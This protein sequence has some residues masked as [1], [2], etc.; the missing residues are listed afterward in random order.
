M[1]AAQTLGIT[2]IIDDMMAANAEVHR[3][4]VLREKTIVKKA[5]HWDIGQTWND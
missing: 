2:Q 1:Q 4:I 5:S 3:L